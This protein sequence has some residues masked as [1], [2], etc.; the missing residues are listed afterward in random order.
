MKKSVSFIVLYFLLTLVSLSQSP[1]DYYLSKPLILDPNIPT[2]KEILG[3]E[4]GEWH[5]SHDQLVQYMY[6]LAKASDRIEIEEYARTYENRPLLL[7]KISSPDNI[8]KLESIRREHVKISDINSHEA[9]DPALLPIIAYLGYSIHGNEASGSNA[10]MLVAYY[11]AAAQNDE[12]RKWLESTVILLDPCYNP[13]GLNR[14]ANWV[15]SK[16]SIHLVSDPNNIEQNEPWPN[17]RTN[18]YWF[19]LNRD[20]LPVQ[21]PESKGRVKLFHH[22]K[23]NILTDH[24]EMGTN[25]TF[26]F[27][28]G[29]PSRNNPLTPSKTYDLTKK[30]A[31]YHAEALD[32]IGALYYSEESYDDF[33]IGKGSSY[34]DING[35]IGILFEQAS[36]R[37]HA[38]QSVNGI[39]TFKFAIRNHF[40]TSLSTLKA[41]YELK[42][43]ILNHQKKFYAEILEMAAVDKTK[44]YVVQVP[45]DISKLRSF[46]QILDIHQINTYHLSKDFKNFKSSDSFIIPMEQ[47]QYRMIK[48]IF[49]KNTHFQDSLFYDVSAWTLPLAFD[50]NYEPLT[51]KNSVQSFI[52]ERISNSALKPENKKLEKSSYGYAFAWNDYLSP[53]LLYEIQ[54]LGIRT[55]T[56]SES[57]YDSEGKYF[58]RGSII[59]PVQN[60]NLNAHQIYTVLDDLNWKYPSQIAGL[61]SGN[62]SSIQLGSNKFQSLETPKPLL[63]IGDGV[64][65]YEAGEV[66]HLLDTKMGI[67]LPMISIDKL[68]QI[69]LDNYNTIIMVDGNYGTLAQAKIKTWLQNGGTI[70]TLR[71]AGKWISDAG[72]SKIKFKKITQ[73]STMKYQSYNQES[74]AKGSQ[75]IGGTIFETQIDLSHP[76]AYGLSDST[77]PIHKKGIQIMETLK[78]PYAHPIHYV[79]NPLMAGYVSKENLKS[80][81]DTPAVGLSSFGKGLIISFNDNP[82]FRGYWFGTSKVFLNALFFSGIINSGTTR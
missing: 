11:L 70:I 13:D 64:N 78:N 29:I 56:S 55:K 57:W 1:L 53:A 65:T 51:E 3:Y 62:N 9:F 18:H 82:N 43:E 37:S 59:I 32:K 75:K 81:S 34:P 40:T 60:Q 21:N 12:I 41:A 77:L 17:S 50:L 2:P 10:A 15:N 79:S 63:V 68:N 16:K 67:P 49:E 14:F 42:D 45:G 74:K 58:T 71:S 5:V 80:I 22:W 7:L 38:Q 20:W 39:L 47:N 4:V 27:Q 48:A 31:K 25:S 69:V 23:P 26:F 73:D 8:Q 61:N 33:Y 30:I 19:D 76:L 6:A 52:G 72:L 46:I 66:W 24:H 44:A 28:P 36:A 35:G 54:K